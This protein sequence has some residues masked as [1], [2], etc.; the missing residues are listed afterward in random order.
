MPGQTFEKTTGFAAD[1]GNALAEWVGE[2]L[3][4]PVRADNLTKL[5]RLGVDERHIFIILP[6]MA[7]VGFEVTEL[8]MRSD[9]PL[10]TIPPNLPPEITH[11]WVASVW[12][13]SGVRW[14]P[15]AGWEW[16]AT[17]AN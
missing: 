12:G 4:Q 9:A 13:H 3:R 16:F 14:S 5:M 8:F 7:D 17:Q 10:P 1:D 15:E 2:W 11:V 6:S